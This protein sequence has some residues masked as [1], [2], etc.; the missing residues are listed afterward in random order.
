MARYPD[1]QRAADLSP[2]WPPPNS[3]LLPVATGA[4]SLPLHRN[5]RRKTSQ[6]CQVTTIHSKNLNRLLTSSRPIC[7][8]QDFT[9]PKL[10]NVKGKIGA[11]VDQYRMR[12]HA[13]L[14]TT[15]SRGH[16]WW[17]RHWHDDRHC[18]RAE[19]RQ[20]LHRVSQGEAAQG[21]AHSPP[22]FPTL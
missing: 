18:V 12:T 4:Q 16:R 10:F 13:T 3:A 20:G 14:K 5:I 11:Y 9:I 22:S 7:D 17:V 15:G 1:P 8:T 2:C 6:L 21:G 19:R